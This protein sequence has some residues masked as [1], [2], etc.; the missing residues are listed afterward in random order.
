MHL[1]KS[2][3]P[4]SALTLPLFPSPLPSFPPLGLGEIKLQSFYYRPQFL[5]TRKA[6][7]RKHREETFLN[8]TVPFQVPLSLCLKV[9]IIFLFQTIS[10]LSIEKRWPC[11]L[12]RT[13]PAATTQ[14]T[15]LCWTVTH[16]TRFVSCAKVK[17]QS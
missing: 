4:R 6:I 8:P 7:P 16:L 3:S 12:V 10:F 14:V 11:Y 13:Q 1:V 15:H 9:E 5:L 2:L 17:V